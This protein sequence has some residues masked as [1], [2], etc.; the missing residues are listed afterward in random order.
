MRRRIEKREIRKIYEH[1]GSY[2]MTL[3]KEVVR[4]LN[5]RDKQK[6]VAKKYGKGVLITDWKK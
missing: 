4:S 2:A 5:W 1:G 6:V 3:P